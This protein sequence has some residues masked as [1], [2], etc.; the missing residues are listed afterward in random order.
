MNPGN[1]QAG[2]Q[3]WPQRPGGGLP[4]EGPEGDVLAGVDPV[5]QHGG[6]VHPLDCGTPQ[7][8]ELPVFWPVHVPEGETTLPPPRNFGAVASDCTPFG[9][10]FMH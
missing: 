7:L 2:G 8:G 5:W 6:R 1:K 10:V 3:R 9:T 4:G